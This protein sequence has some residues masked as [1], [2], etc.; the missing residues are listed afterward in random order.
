MNR[1][2]AGR[3]AQDQIGIGGS[4]L[5]FGSAKARLARMRG[6]EVISEIG[7]AQSAATERPQDETRSA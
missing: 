6:G 3:I 5:P 7:H 4:S 2:R 1:V